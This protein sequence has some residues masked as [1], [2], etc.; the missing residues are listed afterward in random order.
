MILQVLAKLLLYTGAMIVVG[1]VTSRTFTL[2]ESVAANN[3]NS[4]LKPHCWDES[5]SRFS[6]YAPGIGWFSCVLALLAMFSLQLEALELPVDISSATMLLSTGWG[7]GFRRLA[8]AVG[9]GVV[10]YSLRAPLL[11]QT[12]SVIFV[13]VMMGGM[14]HAAADESWPL[15]SRALD[16]THVIAVGAWIG[17]LLFVSQARRGNWRNF[18]R[19][20][21]IAAPFVVLSGVGASLLRLYGDTPSAIVNSEYGQVLAIKTALVVIALVLGT[22]HRN[23]VGRGHPP[24]PAFVGIELLVISGVLVATGVLTGTGMPSE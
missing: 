12:I 14:G 8:S 17:G 23:E 18:S 24:R 5:M 16:A 15:T 22:R 2:M 4:E 3:A 13:A 10:V 21:T 20:A 9:I 19:M 11:I 1:H 7:D 6:K